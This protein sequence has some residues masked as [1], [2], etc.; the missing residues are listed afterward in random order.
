MPTIALGIETAEQ[1]K[2]AKKERKKKSIS[3]TPGAKRPIFYTKVVFIFIYMCF[4]ICLNS[5]KENKK[6]F[7]YTNNMASS[8]KS[9]TQSTKPAEIVLF[10]RKTVQ[11]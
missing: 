5:G 3:F 6:F 1:Q 9:F 4:L 8:V 2:M 10:Y 7:E 11:A